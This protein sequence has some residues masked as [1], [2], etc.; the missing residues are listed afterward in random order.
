MVWHFA[1]VVPGR[2]VQQ[3]LTLSCRHR[4]EGYR[5]QRCNEDHHGGHP[6]R[7]GPTTRAMAYLWR[8]NQSHARRHPIARVTMD[9]GVNKLVKSKF[10]VGD[11]DELTLVPAVA[12]DE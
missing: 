7:V 2:R 3:C 11:H 10:C 1:S 12:A 4:Q 5:L 6:T 9:D 8:R